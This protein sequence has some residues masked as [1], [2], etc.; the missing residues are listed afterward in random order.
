MPTLHVIGAGMAGLSAATAAVERGWRVAVYEQAGHAGGRC[1]SYK[2]RALDRTIDNGN[3]LLL[4]GNRSVA[5]YLRRT[6]GSQALMTE[7]AARFPF[8]D[9]TTGKRWTVDL[10]NNRFPGWVLSSSRR[11]PGTKITD[12][13]SFYNILSAK[14][15]VTIETVLKPYGAL[16]EHFWRPISIAVLNTEPEA[17]QAQ[18]MAPVIRETIGR[19]GHAC[20]PMIAVNGLGS[21][22]VD[23]AL[24]YLA[25][26]GTDIWFSARLR[27]IEPRN[28]TPPVLRFGDTTIKPAADDAVVLAVPPWSAADLVPGLTVPDEHRAI[29][30]GHFLL[31]PE[32]L[33]S[34]VNPSFVGLFG[35]FAEWI[36]LRGDVASVTVSAADPHIDRDTD[37]LAAGLWADVARTLDLDPGTIPNHRIV[38]ERR[39]TFAQTPDQVRLRPASQA[40]PTGVY[41][42]GDWTDTGLPA[43]IEGAIRSGETAVR[44][45]LSGS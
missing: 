2:D 37:E 45:A 21:A 7:P 19:G 40:G 15:N 12:Y 30:N 34:S 11:V 13:F 36:F 14:N 38:K 31:P 28:G 6:G 5:Q 24:A 39:A 25:A 23:P 42:A 20:R 16:Y 4:S 41:L 29:L 17:A 1:R 10:G 43:T 33:K 22:F 3:H 8:V 26:H 44:L 9:L 18:L 32:T 35:G 27:A